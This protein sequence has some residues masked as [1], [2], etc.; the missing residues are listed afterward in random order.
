MASIA[1]PPDY[2]ADRPLLRRLHDRRD[3]LVVAQYR[4]SAAD[5]LLADPDSAAATILRIPEP[6]PAHH[7][8]LL[9]FG[10][11]GHLYIGTGRRRPGR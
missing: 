7:G 5:P 4:R 1:F 3:A 6:T 2:A 11:D 8:G 10:P 9:A